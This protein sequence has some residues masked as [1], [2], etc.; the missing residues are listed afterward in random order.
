[1]N[2]LV[3]FNLC[4]LTDIELAIRVDEQTDKM[5]KTGEI[6]SRNIPAKPDEDYDLLV[7]E[8]VKRFRS[9]VETENKQ[10]RD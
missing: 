3:G 8:L 7:G 1:M 5:Y 6:P 4:T 10:V 2:S 9:K